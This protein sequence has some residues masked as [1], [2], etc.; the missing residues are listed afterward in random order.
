MLSRLRSIG[1]HLIFKD[2][3]GYN[4]KD[5]AFSSLVSIN[6]SMTIA[7]LPIA[8]NSPFNFFPVLT[9]LIGNYSI[10]GTSIPGSDID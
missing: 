2:L 4:F 9:T 5:N 1:R 3:S 10:T 6:G 8:E 7:N